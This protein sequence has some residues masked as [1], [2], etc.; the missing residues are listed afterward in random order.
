MPSK[1]DLPLIEKML[2]VQI[3]RRAA[4]EQ[5][6]AIAAGEA[7]AARSAERDARQHSHDANGE[8][9]QYISEAGFS[10]EYSTALCAR[11]I[12]REAAAAKAAQLTSQREQFH[13]QQQDAWRKTQAQVKHTEGSIRRVK[14]KRARTHEERRLAAIEERITFTWWQR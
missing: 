12:E 3:S 13:L 10:P 14:R 7:A 6:V 4:A 11:A 2:A 8:W 5:A 9:S 1:R